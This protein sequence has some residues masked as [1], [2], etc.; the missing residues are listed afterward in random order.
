[1]R[2]LLIPIFALGACASVERATS[3]IWNDVYHASCKAPAIRFEIASTCSLGWMENGQCV[4]GQFRPL[5]NDIVIVNP[6]G[7]L[8]QTSLAHEL[9]HAYLLC[10]SVRGGDPTHSERS[11]TSRVR[12]AN[13][14]LAKEGL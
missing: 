7:Y 6:S 1:M 3:L 9:Y 12:D 8:H 4:K 13:S 11:W 2:L 10:Q 14:R 5:E